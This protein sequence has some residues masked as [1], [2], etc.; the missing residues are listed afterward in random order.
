[1]SSSMIQSQSQIK[2]GER[3]TM[4]GNMS[5]SLHYAAKRM[6]SSAGNTYGF[7][8]DKLDRQRIDDAADSDRY[9]AIVNAIDAMPDDNQR[10]LSLAS[11]FARLAPRGEREDW[12]QAIYLKLSM[13]C[14]TNS[15]LAYEIAK[16][17]QKN[18]MRS[19]IRYNGNLD[20][21]SDVTAENVSMDDSSVART[22]ED[23]VQSIAYLDDEYDYVE[24]RIDST[25]LFNKIVA[26]NKRIVGIAN[27]RLRTEALNTADRKYLSRWLADIRPELVAMSQ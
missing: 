20:M 8:S 13:A 6:Q 26:G 3:E 4:S 21:F 16:N 18:L 25:L 12:Q 11:H 7:G 19:H 17:F 2:R 22:I 24:S 10:W 1:M 15:A 9:T 5:V 23:V 14:P 27:K